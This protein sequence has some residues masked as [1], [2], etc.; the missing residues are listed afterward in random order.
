MQYKD[1]GKITE[2]EILKNC[3][4]VIADIRSEF[5]LVDDRSS[6]PIENAGNSESRGHARVLTK[7]SSYNSN[8]RPVYESNN[9]SIGDYNTGGYS[10]N[11]DVRQNS[12]A[13]YVLVVAAIIAL[14]ILVYVVSTTILNMINGVY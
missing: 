1:F 9:N 13:S 3:P 5:N 4:K 2:E 6:V 11:G 10:I 7:D 14:I 8:P 12:G